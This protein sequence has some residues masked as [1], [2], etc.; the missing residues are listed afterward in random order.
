MSNILRNK[1]LYNQHKY[2][3]PKS[4]VVAKKT[5]RLD[6]ECYEP[7]ASA[8]AVGLKHVQSTKQQAPCHSPAAQHIPVAWADV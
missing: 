6:A 8:D 1:R 7:M 4:V 2:L 5:E 3:E